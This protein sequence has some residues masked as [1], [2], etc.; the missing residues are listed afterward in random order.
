MVLGDSTEHGAQ[1]GCR[2]GHQGRAKADQRRAVRLLGDHADPRNRRGD[3]GLGGDRRD[4]E[5]RAVRPHVKPLPAH[6]GHDRQHRAGDA[7][8]R[9]AQHHAAHAEMP[10]HP[11]PQ[12]RTENQSDA[13][14]DQQ[15]VQTAVLVGGAQGIERGAQ[16]DRNKE[17][18]RRR[19]PAKPRLRAGDHKTRPIG[20]PH[21]HPGVRRGRSH[22]SDQQRRD[23]RGG[24]PGRAEPQQIAAIRHFVAARQRRY[25]EQDHEGGDHGSDG[26]LDQQQLRAPGRGQVARDQVRVGHTGEGEQDPA[27][28]TRQQKHR[29]GQHPVPGNRRIAQDQCGRARRDRR[30]QQM[31]HPARALQH[32]RRHRISHHGADA[33]GREQ[34]RGHPGETLMRADEGQHHGK[35]AEPHADVVQDALRE[36]PSE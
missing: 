30:Q 22:R 1:P 34:Q 17:Q 3:N 28:R 19:I 26:P 11:A 23:A 8:Q 27:T 12:R 33:V 24:Q 36:Q 5:H 13:G 32:R 7:E 20:V 25:D 6:L 2:H 35:I 31:T 29:R 14:K 4:Q 21:R 16:G 15:H 18:A 9:T 10:V